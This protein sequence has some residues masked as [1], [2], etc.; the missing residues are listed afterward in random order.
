MP[1]ISIIIPTLN[2]EK[3]L[4]LLLE[5]IKRQ[6]YK[7]YEIIV[8]DSN[9]KDRTRDIAREFNSRIVEGG[10]P[11]VARNKGAKAAKGNILVFLDADSILIHSTFLSHI[12][13][14]FKEDIDYATCKL[15]PI[16]N[17]IIDFVFFQFSNIYYFMNQWIEPHAPGTAIFCRRDDFLRIGGFNENIRVGEDHEFAERAKKHG[18]KFKIINETIATS[19]RRF[20]REGKFKLAK[21]YL[22]FE[23]LKHIQKLI[24][25]YTH[26]EIDKTIIDY[27][28]EERYNEN[29]KEKLEQYL[30]FRKETRKLL[31]VVNKSSIEKETFKKE[32]EQLL[33]DSHLMK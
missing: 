14:T 24:Q 29:P 31:Y 32:I 27:S 17:D 26:E 2:E 6:K 18:L 1:N 19:T 13:K 21:K 30:K 23:T 8:A 9:S 25:K 20:E 22:K 15:E 4:P 7:N 28:F 3:Y 5:S 12:A 10:I 33:N 16:S 11:S